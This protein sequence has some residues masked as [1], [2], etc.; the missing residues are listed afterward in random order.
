MMNPNTRTARRVGWVG[1][2]VASSAPQFAGAAPKPPDAI[3]AAGRK[4]FQ[5]GLCASC[6]TVK[7]AGITKDPAPVGPDLSGLGARMDLAALDAWL[8]KGAN[9]NG[10]PHALQFTGQDEAFR[11]LATWLLRPAPKRPR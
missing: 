2:L 10:K 7:A 6:H 9:R 8:R 1:I 3:D 5:D 11:A 4:A